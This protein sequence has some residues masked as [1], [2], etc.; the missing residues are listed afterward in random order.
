MN[1]DDKFMVG[2]TNP[3]G[4]GGCMSEA[5]I[6]HKTQ[7]TESTDG[8]WGQRIIVY[9]HSIE[10]AETL[11]DRVLAAI[12]LQQGVQMIREFDPAKMVADLQALVTADGGQDYT[13]VE[14]FVAEHIDQLGAKT[15]ND[16]ATVYGVTLRM[17]VQTMQDYG[18]KLS[19][20]PRV[21]QTAIALEN[22]QGERISDW[23]PAHRSA[24]L[25][26]LEAA[27]MVNNTDHT[28]T[29]VAVVCTDGSRWIMPHP[30]VLA[31]QDKA[32]FNNHPQVQE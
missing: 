10:E 19:L 30:R 2:D 18:L 7:D 25:G 26:N 11:R 12:H 1:K 15:L 23:V 14:C 8:V 29:A 5:G 3:A 13:E 27:D 16:D 9:G 20:E 28:Q 17:L 32:R 24:F 22:L 4:D 31:P 6:H 21:P